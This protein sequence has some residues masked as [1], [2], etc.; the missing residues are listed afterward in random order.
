[1][2]APGRVAEVALAAPDAGRSSASPA[3]YR[4]KARDCRSVADRDFLWAVA[5]PEHLAA[6]A[7]RDVRELRR[8]R[9]PRD[10]WQKA[11]YRMVLR[12]VPLPALLA[13]L[14]AQADEPDLLP[15][16]SL[17]VRQ[18]SRLAAPRPVPEPALWVPPEQRPRALP[19]RLALPLAQPEPRVHSVSPRLARRLLE[20]VRPAQQVSSARPSQPRPSLLF[21][22]WQPLP[23][24]LR[25]RRLPE[26]S[27]ALSQRRP[28]GSSS[29]A[30]SFP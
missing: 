14:E 2:V 16:Q 1:M 27:C 26:C 29:S 19:V 4:A 20:M 3:T 25:L 24:G 18:A 7:R 22:L 30:S 11:V 23:L 9:R 15:G 28:L 10:A 6:S 17:L 21:P 12:V 13:F 5:E 8:A